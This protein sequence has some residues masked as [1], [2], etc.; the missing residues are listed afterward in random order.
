MKKFSGKYKIIKKFSDEQIQKW[1][2]ELITLLK[3]TIQKETEHVKEYVDHLR[4]LNEDL[5]REQLARKIISRRCLKA[6]GVGAV[7]G[8]GGFIMMPI[9]M[10]GDMYYTFRIQARMV[11]ALAHLY[12]WNIHDDDFETDIL[13]VMGGSTVIGSFSQVGIK[14]G[15]EYTKK[16]IQKYITR[17]VM[18]RLN[19]V[20]SR[21]I[22]SKA[23]EKSLISFT[24]LV[25]IIGAPIG[26]AF[27]YLGTMAVGRTALNFYKG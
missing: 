5:D 21:K 4:D 19:R 26:G 9:T 3:T 23:G 1:S 7:C 27:D 22:I 15:Q 24:K 10:P 8:L 25:P 17:E 12:D 13:I 14:I 11:L 6:G 20:I 2:E 18:K 16:S